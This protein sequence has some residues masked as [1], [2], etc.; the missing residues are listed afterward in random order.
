MSPPVVHMSPPVVHMSPPVVHMSP[1]PVLLQCPPLHSTPHGVH[2]ESTRSICG[3]DCNRTLDLVKLKK[4]I[5]GVLVESTRTPC[6]ILVESIRTVQ[7]CAIKCTHRGLNTQSP[8]LMLI[9][10]KFSQC[11]RSL[12]I[13]PRNAWPQAGTDLVPSVLCTKS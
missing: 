6:G 4:S 5:G 9:Q 10:I 11:I 2:M 7:G 8:A 3:V 12:C 13:K 1:P